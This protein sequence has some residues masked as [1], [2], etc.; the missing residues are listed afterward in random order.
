MHH[1]PLSF[2]LLFG[3][4][5]LA[6]ACIESPQSVLDYDAVATPRGNGTT[7]VS[8]WSVTLTRA[9]VALGPFYFCA[10]ASGSSTLCA[11]S[12]AEVA[13]V[14]V[15]NALPGGPSP[16]GKVHG[17]SGSIESVSYDLGISWFDTQTA[18]TPAPG[19]PGGHSMRLEGSAQKG[20]VR[21][22]FVADVDVVPQYQ[23]QNAISTA[24][25]VATVDSA[26]ARLSVELDAAAWLRQLDFD[27]IATKLAASRESTFVIQPGM[28]EH[29]AILV[30]LKNLSPPVFTWAKASP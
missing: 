28:P 5:P 19:L 4:L 6:G 18:P 8:G 3:L 9:D 13:R 27:A 16:I 23:G 24:P 15:V 29:T 22:P 1:P 10:A 30:G 26:A 14:S 2:V 17:F 20:A 7:Q 11:S 21:V 25:A 12:V